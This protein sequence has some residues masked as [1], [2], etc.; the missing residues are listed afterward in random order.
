MQQPAQL[1]GP[2]PSGPPSGMPTHAR[3]WQDVPTGQVAPHAP[4]LA[5]SEFRSLQTAPHCAIGA[6]QPVPPSEA[7]Q[8]PPPEQVLPGEHAAQVEPPQPQAAIPP[9][10]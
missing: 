3:A 5:G 9:P 7:G 8:Q 10:G 4:Q 6:G 2:Q 1:A